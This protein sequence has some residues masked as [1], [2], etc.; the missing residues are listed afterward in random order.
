MRA[1]ITTT[2]TA[3]NDRFKK[4]HFVRATLRNVH[5]VHFLMPNADLFHDESECRSH[6][7]VLVAK[8][9][10]VVVVVAVAIALLSYLAYA[11]FFA[12]Q[13]VAV[14]IE[15]D[16][17]R[18]SKSQIETAERSS[19]CRLARV[20]FLN[21]RHCWI[22]ECPTLTNYAFYHLWY[23]FEL[24]KMHKMRFEYFIADAIHSNGAFTYL[25]DGKD[26]ILDGK[27]LLTTKAQRTNNYGY[28]RLHS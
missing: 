2:P 20:T 28:Y 9:V 7:S 27:F 23:G 16:N 13:S 24:L 17:L 22:D 8:L 14:S 4:P 19:K 18:R 12:H 10:V 1:T 26:S 5:F 11:A 6:I 21:C 15:L 3:T 25:V